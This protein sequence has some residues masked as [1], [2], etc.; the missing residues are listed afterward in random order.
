VDFQSKHWTCPFCF[1]RNAMTPYYAENI[2][3]DRLPAE[4]MQD[5]TTMDF[6]LPTA[7]PACPPAFLYVVDACA[8]EEELESLKDSILQSLE[9]LPPTAL[10]GLVTY[11][12]MVQ[13]H[14]MASASDCPRSYVFKG[15][16]DYESAQVAS[17]LG[18][19]PI[20]AGPGTPPIEGLGVAPAG[21]LSA[22]AISALQN[23]G[24]KPGVASMAVAAAVKELGDDAGLNE[25]VRVALKRAAG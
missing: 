14:E 1:T 24:F 17:L 6:I 15:T 9:L 3:P 25:L 11:G 16:K 4:L 2:T 8:S 20:A 13:V 22:D 23:L 21:S 7:R 5:Y 19:T 12:T 10:V 18:V